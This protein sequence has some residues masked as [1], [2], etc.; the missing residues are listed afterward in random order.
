MQN[1]RKAT[2]CSVTAKLNVVFLLPVKRTGSCC[3]KLNHTNEKISKLFETSFYFWKR[4]STWK[5]NKSAIQW[6]EYEGF[7]YECIGLDKETNL[8]KDKDDFARVEGLI[9]AVRKAGSFHSYLF[10]LRH[11]AI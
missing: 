8:F 9:Q 5:F 7:V 6:S 11:Y 1:K 4:L 3:Q 2:R 10:L